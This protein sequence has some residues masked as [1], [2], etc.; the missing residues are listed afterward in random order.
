MGAVATVALIDNWPRAPRA[1]SC[2]IVRSCPMRPSCPQA[3]AAGLFFLSNFETNSGAASATAHYYHA[4][5]IKL[6]SA[7]LTGTEDGG[8][9]L[10]FHRCKYIEARLLA[11]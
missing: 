3:Q 11:K 5:A 8:R 4:G 6:A 1:D 9:E 2:R 7:S 10:E